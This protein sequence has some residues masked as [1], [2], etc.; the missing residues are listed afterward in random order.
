MKP[1][2]SMSFKNGVIGAVTPLDTGC[3]GI[4]ANAVAVTDGFQLNKAYQL[5]SMRDVSAIKLTDTIDNHRL[6]KAIAE[7]YAEAGEGTEL[8]IYGVAKTL[9]VS[10]FFTSVAGAA[11]P[12]ENL[13]NSANGK[14]RGVFTVNAT[15]ATVTVDDGMD[16]DV[17][18]AA[19]KAQ[20]L[21]E[22]YTATKY[23]PYFTILEGY[24]F[25]GDKVEL[26]ALTTLAHNA[27]G[28]IIGDTE[29]RTGSTASKGAAVG[30]LAG[31][32]AKYGAKVNAGKV[33][34]GA[35]TAPQLYIL[36]T[37][38]ELF[39]CEAL[40]DKGYITFTT[41]QSIA[42]Y[43]V[44]DDPLACTPSDDYHY[45][46]RRRVINEAF[47]HTYISL[48]NFILDEV[49]A[50]N[51]GTIVATYAKT[52]ESTVIREIVKQMASDLSTDSNDPKDVG[53]KCFV[54]PEQNVVVN[55]KIDVVVSIRPYGYNRWIDVLIG[56]ELEN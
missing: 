6:Y 54:D 40:Y 8:W 11:T 13:L 30:V 23:A 56:F 19:G 27:V 29:K 53:V 48:L 41:H 34:N 51:N 10:D 44:M 14:I 36:D 9:K 50:N 22:N 39:D 15:S 16:T 28:I 3:F 2:I 5:K 32:L 25:D 35:L 52:I 46:A 24:A 1:R 4:V 38:V 42:G 33:R 21:F 45:L 43:F 7:F 26:S 20:T 18:V 37:P 17:L 47:R 31:R 55:S 12:V 49:P